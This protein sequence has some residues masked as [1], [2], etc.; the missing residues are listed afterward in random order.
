M[1]ALIQ[2]VAAEEEELPADVV[3][4]AVDA[5]PRLIRQEGMLHRQPRFRSAR[6]LEVV[7]VVDAVVVVVRA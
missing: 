1:A 2:L 4:R 5:A 6:A 7:A 3:A